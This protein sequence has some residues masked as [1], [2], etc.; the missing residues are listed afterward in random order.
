MVLLLGSASTAIAGENFQI[1]EQIWTLNP[2]GS[3]TATYKKTIYNQNV[4]VISKGSIF[5]KSLSGHKPKVEFWTDLE[6]RKIKYTSERKPRGYDYFYEYP[7][8]IQK[9][10]IGGFVVQ[11]P[12]LDYEDFHR[13]GDVAV[14]SPGRFWPEANT[15][16]IFKLRLPK[17][18]RI[19]KLTPERFTL[20]QQGDYLEA[21][22]RH[23]FEKSEG[24]PTIHCEFLP[25]KQ[26]MDALKTADDE[27][28]VQAQSLHL[29]GDL[30][31]EIHVQSR[32]TNNGREPIGE[33]RFRNSYDDLI[34]V[35][36][37]KGRS[38]KVRKQDHPDGN[39]FLYNVTLIDPIKPGNISLR[40]G[41]HRAGD[42]VYRWGEDKV[43]I[44]KGPHTPIPATD[45]SYRIIAPK[46]TRLVQSL[47][48]SATIYEEDDRTV[49]LVKKHL[50]RNESIFF[51]VILD[52]P[53]I[54]AR[55]LENRP[56]AEDRLVGKAIRRYS[57]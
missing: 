35:K 33:V 57:D 6:G 15:L 54:K 52:I 36:D 47:F 2:D 25:G 50:G 14:I 23:Y 4:E 21:S 49:I 51:A 44:I 28:H 26:V 20:N 37:E 17:D 5:L 8:P 38:L 46:G 9:G 29:N 43:C 42:A 16:F 7:E 30:T 41:I 48:E 22:F 12:P 1:E 19:L 56:R 11:A 32:M 27:F 10:E 40:T 3:R 55:D 34:D 45:F 24:M 13:V 18:A 31:A 53:G 39:G